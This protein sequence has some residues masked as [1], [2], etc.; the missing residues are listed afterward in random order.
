MFPIYC[1]FFFFLLGLITV[2]C[3]TP[4]KWGLFI[5]TAYCTI[6]IT[7]L[8]AWMLGMRDATQ[9]RSVINVL[10]SSMQNTTVIF[11]VRLYL[12][13]PSADT[14]RF[15]TSKSHK[16]GS[17][18]SLARGMYGFWIQFCYALLQQNIQGNKEKGNVKPSKALAELQRQGGKKAQRDREC[19]KCLQNVTQLSEISHNK[20]K[21]T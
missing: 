1:F 12:S 15:L 2:T 17:E 3:Y 10:G 11:I 8:N 21:I 18:R 19:L 5:K 6:Y 16:A 9:Q 20:E 13:S 4:H 7:W 14:I